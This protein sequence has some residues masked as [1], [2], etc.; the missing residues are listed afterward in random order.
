[1]D[2]IQQFLGKW[3]GSGTWHD[4]AGKSGGYQVTQECGRRE[5]T[6]EL[7]FCHNFSDSTVTD[8]QFLFAPIDSVIFD[9]VVG[10]A[11]LGNGYILPDYLHYS[12]RAGDAYVEASY[13][14]A[15]PELRVC[16]SSTKNKEGLFVAW[17]EELRKLQSLVQ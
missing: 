2:N 11:K 6:I 1:M 17:H 3:Q 4:A 14:I 7:I 16:G 8:A 13:F 5:S 9:L 10:G 12:L 15:G